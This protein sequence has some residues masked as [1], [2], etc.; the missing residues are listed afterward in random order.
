MIPFEQVRMAERSKLLGWISAQPSA[1]SFRRSEA[2]GGPIDLV[3]RTTEPKKSREMKQGGFDPRIDTEAWVVLPL[4]T[5]APIAAKEFL[6]ITDL[7]GDRRSFEI[8]SAT[9]LRGRD[10]WQLGLNSRGTR[11]T[12]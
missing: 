5:T 2:N 3:V 4:G 9:A 12:A 6:I 10:C 11:P 1:A 8:I 7:A